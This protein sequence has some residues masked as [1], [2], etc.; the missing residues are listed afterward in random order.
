MSIYG[1]FYYNNFE[2][3]NF[4]ED[5]RLETFKS[6]ETPKRSFASEVSQ[7]PKDKFSDSSPEG[8]PK[9]QK[10]RALARKVLSPIGMVSPSTPL[11][12]TSGKSLSFTKVKTK[13]CLN[14]EALSSFQENVEKKEMNS[15]S[16]L[17]SAAESTQM[18]PLSM[19]VRPPVFESK[20]TYDDE[21]EGM[22][23]DF[24]MD[25]QEKSP[26][27][28]EIAPI[29]SESRKFASK[30]P[31]FRLNFEK[32]QD[33]ETA[34]I[35]K[36]NGHPIY[37]GTELLIA[38]GENLSLKFIGKGRFHE[39]WKPERKKPLAIKIVKR[40]FSWKE[41]KLSIKETL[42]GYR[43]HQ[44]RSEML[45]DIRVAKLF[46]ED[47]VWDDGFYVFEYIDG[48]EPTFKDV[49]EIL[50]RMIVEP[51]TFIFDFKPENLKMNNGQVVII[52]PT[53]ETGVKS[54]AD[55]AINLY[56]SINKWFLN[57]DKSINKA[58]L[59]ALIAEFNQLELAPV[60]AKIWK[61]TAQLLIN[62]LNLK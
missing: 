33:D 25:I 5:N 10:I 48:N 35:L 2:K 57:E 14:F 61:V 27:K 43:V 51:S 41:Q 17:T 37:D 8:S 30:D 31:S 23:L 42:Y 1:N 7:S 49:K 40:S 45:G 47:R 6:Q 58:D 19:L 46:N 53:I 62:R 15:F 54:I 28:F 22:D 34:A 38:P 26:N 18:Q 24:E 21:I 55:K 39:A 13:K 56:S 52:D 50:K 36:H 4:L 60:A 9:R 32:S 12:S 44:M 16:S 29:L 11:N 20:K 59:N 3:E